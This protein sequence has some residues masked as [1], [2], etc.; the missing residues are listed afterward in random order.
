MKSKKIIS[1]KRAVLLGS[2]TILMALIAVYAL[3]KNNNSSS[4]IQMLPIIT[5]DEA[6]LNESSQ[7]GDESA[8]TRSPSSK[9]IRYQFMGDVLRIVE[10]GDYEVLIKEAMSSGLKGT[11]MIRSSG[12][13]IDVYNSYVFSEV[14]HNAQEGRYDCGTARQYFKDL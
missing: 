1:M 8:S 7:D 9:T 14:T 12:C 13:E 3:G 5:N 10:G 4:S 6:G 2:I 11:I